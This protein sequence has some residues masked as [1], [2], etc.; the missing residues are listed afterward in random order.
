MKVATWRDGTQTIRKTHT[1]DYQF[2]WSY[3]NTDNKRVSGFSETRANAEKA[4][5][6]DTNWVASRPR[7]MSEY[8][9]WWRKYK[10]SGRLA[11]AEKRT[12][13]IRKTIEI[14]EVETI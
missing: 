10:E 8:H 7:G 3:I 5:Y 6:K 14:V 4:A 11:A 13:D 2:A 1:R 9:P 12:A